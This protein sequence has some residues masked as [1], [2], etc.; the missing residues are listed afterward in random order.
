MATHSS[1]R[2]WEIPWTE[3]PGQAAVHG[4]TTVGLDFATKPPP[5]VYISVI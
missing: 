1:I 3:Q 4:V 2:A 5:S